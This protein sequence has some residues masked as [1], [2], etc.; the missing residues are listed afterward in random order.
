MTNEAFESQEITSNEAESHK[1]FQ[2][3][4]LGKVG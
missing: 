3:L 4:L 2:L 1:H